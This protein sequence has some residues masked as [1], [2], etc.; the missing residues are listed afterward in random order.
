MAS[1]FF[2]TCCTRGRR[3]QTRRGGGGGDG[4]TDLLRSPPVAQRSQLVRMSDAHLV[5]RG[6]VPGQVRPKVLRDFGEVGDILRAREKKK[7]NTKTLAR[8]S[9]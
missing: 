7:N 5:Q 2:S 3:S 1:S 4:V 6:Q 8:A 9:C